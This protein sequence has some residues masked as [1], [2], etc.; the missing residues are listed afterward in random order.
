MKSYTKVKKIITFSLTL[1]DE[2]WAKEETIKG[3]NIF[4]YQSFNSWDEDK[5]NRWSGKMGERGMPKYL[6]NLV[7]PPKIESQFDFIYEDKKLEVKTHGEEKYDQ[8]AELTGVDCHFLLIRE[9]QFAITDCDIYVFCYYEIIK[10]ELH[11][12]GWISKEDIDKKGVICKKG[13]IIHSPEYERSLTLQTDNILIEH[14]DI[15]DMELL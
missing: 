5:D 4:G 3:D 7:L 8:E 10:R 2:K 14:R 6:L 11:I 12:I 1:E 15:N 13:K 9:R